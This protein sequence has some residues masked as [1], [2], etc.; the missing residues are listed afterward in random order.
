MENRS[1]QEKVLD[2]LYAIPEINELV[3]NPSIFSGDIEGH[4]CD[5][6]P[7]GEYNQGDTFDPGVCIDCWERAILK[8]FED[9]E[10][11]RD[12]DEFKS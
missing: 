7:A 12:E 11:E 10:K 8:A 9:S 6:C 5:K 3:Q 4:D 2:L 1:I